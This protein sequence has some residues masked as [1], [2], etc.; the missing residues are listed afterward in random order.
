MGY[1]EVRMLTSEEMGTEPNPASLRRRDAI[2][3]LTHAAQAR[4][5][6]IHE[7]ALE[8]SVR[9]CLTCGQGAPLF[10]LVLHE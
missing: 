5:A 8:A 3:C 2:M 1:E 10:A 7:H 4:K 9:Q 6:D